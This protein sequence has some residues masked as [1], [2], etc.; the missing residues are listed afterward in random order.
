MVVLTW[1]KPAQN[2]HSIEK[3]KNNY[4]INKKVFAVSRLDNRFL[5]YLDYSIILH[6]R[7]HQCTLLTLHYSL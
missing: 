7:H 1:E 4:F 3:N 6:Q 2:G 5:V